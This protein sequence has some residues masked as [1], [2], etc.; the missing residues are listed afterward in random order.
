MIGPDLQHRQ[1]RVFD[2]SASPGF[3]WNN[4]KKKSI[5]CFSQLP[6]L[7]SLKHL[8]GPCICILNDWLNI[9]YGIDYHLLCIINCNLYLNCEKTNLPV[10]F[11]LVKKQFILKYSSPNL[12]RWNIEKYIQGPSLFGWNPH[13]YDIIQGVCWFIK[14]DVY[15]TNI[16]RNGC[17]KRAKK[18]THLHCNR[19]HSEKWLLLTD[20]TIEIRCLLCIFL[21]LLAIPLDDTHLTTSQVFMGSRQ[22]SYF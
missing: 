8:K 17:M 10:I 19:T 3:W 12:Y 18:T 1:H 14:M 11:Y 21:C 2:P 15:T 4:N 16:S 20:S 13:L 22:G 6:H 5:W 7:T 9:I